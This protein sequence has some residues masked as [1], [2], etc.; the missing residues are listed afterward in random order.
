VI[1]ED[2]TQLRLNAVCEHCNSGWMNRLETT[3]RPVLSNLSMGQRQRVGTSIARVLARWAVK[4]AMVR[5]HVENESRHVFNAVARKEL[6]TAGRLP[7]KAW[8]WIA[9]A[10][11]ANLND[12]VRH[13]WVDPVPGAPP[14]PNTII[15]LL[16]LH[17]LA[18]VVFWCPIDGF[19]IVDLAA[20]TTSPFQRIWPHPIAAVWPRQPKATP[21]DLHA[22][23]SGDLM[24]FGSY[25]TGINPLPST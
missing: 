14:R 16:I 12:C 11:Q 3:A 5:E 8:V 1:P 15:Y 6:A 19:P 21:Y 4:T 22:A 20:F 17:Q 10:E 24:L 18:L 2:F 9:Q 7:G 25:A 13:L 23:G